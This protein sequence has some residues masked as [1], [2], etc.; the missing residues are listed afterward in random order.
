MRV[1]WMRFYAVFHSL[2]RFTMLS[3]C[4][5]VHFSLFLSAPF[6]PTSIKLW[7][8]ICSFHASTHTMCF[9]SLLSKLITFIAHA[10]THTNYPRHVAYVTIFHFI[11]FHFNFFRHIFSFSCIGWA[12]FHMNGRWWHVPSPVNAHRVDTMLLLTFSRT[13]WINFRHRKNGKKKV[14][15]HLCVM[16][17]V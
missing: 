12:R 4:T 7:H 6:F 11:S 17:F 3:F 16:C 14:S 8:P 1:Y 9:L 10:R 2:L 5:V 13:T 15:T